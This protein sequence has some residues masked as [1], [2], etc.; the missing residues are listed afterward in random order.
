MINDSSGEYMVL[1]L[2]WAYN[3]AFV[4]LNTY[5]TWPILRRIITTQLFVM[6][7]P[8]P[9][10]LS[11][12]PPFPGLAWTFNPTNTSKGDSFFVEFCIFSFL[13]FFT[14]LKRISCAILVDILCR[15]V[16]KLRLKSLPS[17]IML[18]N[19]IGI[20]R[21]D[22]TCLSIEA[23]SSKH[24]SFSNDLILIAL[25]VL[26]KTWLCSSLDHVHAA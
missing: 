15:L 21:I 11:A 14:L 7:I 9:A 25:A 1:K 20:P 26:E 24:S 8:S 3:S 22:Y 23:S 4:V 17:N 6:L 18:I 2:R 13:F 16:N 5:L 10:R 12:K 19:L